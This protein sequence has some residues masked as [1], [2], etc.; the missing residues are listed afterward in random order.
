[1]IL[2]YAH[3]YSLLRWMTWYNMKTSVVQTFSNLSWHWQIFNL[4]TLLGN[5]ERIIMWI[6]KFSEFSLLQFAVSMEKS[7]RALD[8]FQF[9]KHVWYLGVSDEHLLDESTQKFV[10][11]SLR[12][13]KEVKEKPRLWGVCHLA[14]PQIVSQYLTCIQVLVAWHTQYWPGFTPPESRRYLCLDFSVLSF[15]NPSS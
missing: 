10:N 7:W 3:T 15:E 11:G 13:Q 1:M 14:C 4:E 12:K 9:C 5:E 6:F 2:R 8:S